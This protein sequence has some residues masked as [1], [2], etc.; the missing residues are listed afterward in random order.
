[1][2]INNQMF[3]LIIK[4]THWDNKLIDKF[5]FLSISYKQSVF[6]GFQWRLRK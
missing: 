2:Q 4:V 6:G 5:I 1:M 3:G